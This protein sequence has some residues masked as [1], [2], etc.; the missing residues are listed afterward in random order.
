[1]HLTC[2]GLQHSLPKT[3][4]ALT[5]VTFFLVPNTIP[6]HPDEGRQ[7]AMVLV[8]Q[9]ITKGILTTPVCPTEKRLQMQWSKHSA[10][11]GLEGVILELGIDAAHD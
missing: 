5:P 9:T 1:M 2:L 3:T 11:S 8:E 4:G 10:L 6:S 7:Q